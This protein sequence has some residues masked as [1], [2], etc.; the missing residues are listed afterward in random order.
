MDVDLLGSHSKMKSAATL[1]A[2]DIEFA[3]GP[4]HFNINTEVEQKL[5]TDTIEAFVGYML[6]KKLISKH[7]IVFLCYLHL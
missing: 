2:C 6:S 5:L 4:P 1:T 7:G 3:V